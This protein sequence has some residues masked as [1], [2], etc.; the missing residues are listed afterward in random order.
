M[1]KLIISL[2]LLSTLVSCQS[3]KYAYFYRELGRLDCE[4]AE[5]LEKGINH[6]KYNPE[7]SLTTDSLRGE[8]EVKLN[9]YQI[10]TDK[11]WDLDSKIK[12]EFTEEQATFDYLEGYK[13]CN[14]DT[15]MFPKESINEPRKVK[16]VK[17]KQI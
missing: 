12:S 16:E 1:I 3:T 9:N 8:Y 15:C 7:D 17:L 13:K 6:S 11:H 5:V 14:C 4:C 10:F 2:F